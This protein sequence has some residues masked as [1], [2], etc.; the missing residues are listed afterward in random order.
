MIG[1]LAE[2]KPAVPHVET[3]PPTLRYGAAAFALRYAAGE[4]W[5]SRGESNP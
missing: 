1:W 5:W 2:P 4:G 3:R